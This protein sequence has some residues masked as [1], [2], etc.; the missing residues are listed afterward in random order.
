MSAFTIKEVGLGLRKPCF[1][2]FPLLP[3]VLF[4]VFQDAAILC[5]FCNVQDRIVFSFK[6]CSEI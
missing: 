2:L 6:N 4:A 1:I 5:P 3:D